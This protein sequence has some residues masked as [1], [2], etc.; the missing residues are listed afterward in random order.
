M[1][2][3]WRTVRQFTTNSRIVYRVPNE[4]PSSNPPRP[5]KASEDEVLG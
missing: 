1:R 4:E 3:F 5:W 2:I